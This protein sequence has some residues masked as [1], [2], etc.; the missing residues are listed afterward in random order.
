[1]KR[2]PLY[3]QLPRV[4]RRRDARQG[5]PL[6]AML[7]VLQE[8]RDRAGLQ[9][10]ELLEGWFV[11]TCD[12]AL[13]P[14]LGALL[15]LELDPSGWVLPE[16]RSLVAD[17]V[18]NRRR[19][20]TAR[21]LADS[22]RQ[23]SGLPA[24]V[25]EMAE[26]VARAPDPTLALPQ[27]A[28]LD[29]RH[30]PAAAHPMG[31]LPAA[32]SVDIRALK[33]REGW[34]HDDSVIVLLSSICASRLEGLAA[35]HAGGR[36][37][38]RWRLHPGGLD[39]PLYR[40]A[41]PE[42]RD[43]ARALPHPL[44]RLELADVLVRGED[45]GPFLRVEEDGAPIEGSRFVVRDLTHWQLPGPSLRVVFGSS[46]AGGALRTAVALTLTLGDV[47]RQVLIEAREGDAHTLADAVERAI[48]RADPTPA[49]RRARVMVCDERLLL[50]P[51]A[52]TASAPRLEAPADGAASALGLDDA[53]VVE[54]LVSE[55]LRR[56]PVT[57]V[58]LTLSGPDTPATPV[59]LAFEGDDPERVVAALQAGLD[60]AGL[61]DWRALRLDRGL[62]LV[63]PPGVRG[64]LRVK[65]PAAA[66]GSAASV[67]L[68]RL[69]AIDP[70]T[71]RV[72]FGRG[73]SPKSVTSDLWLGV[74]GPLGAGQPRRESPPAAGATDFLAVVPDDG[75]G[76]AGQR[77]SYPDLAGALD[78]WES[79]VRDG[80]ILL[81]DSARHDLGEEHVLAVP[82]ATRLCLLADEGES[83]TLVGNLRIAGGGD[84]AR[85]IL[86]GLRL[87][88]DLHID[89]AVSVH[90]QQCTVQGRVLAL[91]DPGRPL[92][93]EAADTILGGL[94]AGPRDVAVSL[95]RTAITG[96]TSISAGPSGEGATLRLRCA[97]A[98]GSVQAHAITAHDC[99]LAGAL[100]I[101]DTTRGSIDGSLLPAGARAPAATRSAR[102]SDG[103]SSP[104]DR[105]RP[106]F[107]SEDPASPRFACLPSAERHSLLTRLG[108]TSEPG[109]YHD[110]HLDRRLR[111]ARRCLRDQLP[112][113]LEGAI[114]LL[115]QV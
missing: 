54:A 2:T 7:A 16:H 83:P 68:A 6:E 110:L 37:R 64:P 80:E 36:G 94:E 53:D 78:A 12:P 15:G 71:S 105:P 91:G 33:G 77:R 22:V 59:A 57:A 95:D 96:P 70:E 88:G 28:S 81:R 45:P 113:G 32:H 18:R 102:W 90:L 99:I 1:M 75:L 39:A 104:S 55:E 4:I 101:G 61:K 21:A 92:R 60:A 56:V 19:K 44:R 42:A 31:L 3:D 35:V 100:D 58:E 25:L 69:V 65:D 93:I 10:H 40:P 50:V 26:Y 74:S 72:T 9:V 41:D 97:T 34:F 76:D 108:A 38:H 73:E 8:E 63:A 5:R 103:S 23:A 115:D 46:P 82:V 87:A 106:A 109:V 85:V 17:T 89:G 79:Q 62:L 114:L 48:R 111:L 43:P 29:V 98:L 52:I 13:L 27:R 47:K 11:E 84:G 86:S 51:G 14:E 107:H 20:G 49:F 67:G 24:A 112:L 30:L 66:P